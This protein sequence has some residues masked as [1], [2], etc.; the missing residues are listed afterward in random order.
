[1]QAG[2]RHKK[3]PTTIHTGQPGTNDNGRTVPFPGRDAKGNARDDSIPVPVEAVKQEPPSILAGQRK[4]TFVMIPHEVLRRRDLPPAAKLIYA[5]I[6]DRIGSNGHAWPGV[7]RLASDTGLCRQTVQRGVT[8]LER[9]G[10]L[11]VER[12]GL[13]LC[14]SYAISTANKTRPVTGRK[15]SPVAKCCYRWPH[16]VTGCGYKMWT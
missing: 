9:Q 5:M 10:L 4:L 7:R 16:S 2:R 13:G 11:I 15:M 3:G 14:N 6:S 12:G 8:Q 1:M